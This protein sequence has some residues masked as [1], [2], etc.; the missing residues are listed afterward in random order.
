MAIMGIVFCHASVF[1]LTFGVDNADFYSVAF[2]NCLRDF[3]IPVFVMLSGA[4]L[5]NRNES[6]KAFFKKRLSRLLVPFLFWALVYIIYSHNYT[7]SNICNIIFGHSGGLGVT[8]WFVWMIML[9]YLGIFIINKLINHRG[10]SIIYVLTVLSLAY[11]IIVKLG[12][13]PYPDRMVY[14]ASF[15]VYIIIGYFI[16]H[17]DLVGSRVNGK[18]LALLG[19][20]VSVALYFYYI[21]GFVVPRSQ[22]SGRLICLG[23]FTPLLL[24]LSVN[25]FIFFKYSDRTGIMEMISKSRL[26]EII[27]L[28]SKYSF[29]IYLVHYLIIDIIKVNFLAYMHH[30]NSFVEILLLFSTVLIISLAVLFVL[31]RLPFINRFSGTH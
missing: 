19:L 24:I 1:F 28:I 4:L 27:T 2:F 21:L 12:F 9:M 20:A 31:D 26:G 14:F 29:G 15:I 30:Y 3:S 16:A 25:V 8:F 11:F 10:E 7:F 23:Y 22:L 6:F 13:S 17:H 18:H 5:L